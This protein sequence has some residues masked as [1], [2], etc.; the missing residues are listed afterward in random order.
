MKPLYSRG[1]AAISEEDAA[2]RI[3]T[4]DRIERAKKNYQKLK[5]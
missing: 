1:A 3:F 4:V 2:E 5:L